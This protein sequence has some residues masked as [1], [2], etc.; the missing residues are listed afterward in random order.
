[1]ANCILIPSLQD[2]LC[3]IS[4]ACCDRPRH[5]LIELHREFKT[6]IIVGRSPDKDGDI[7]SEPSGIPL[8]DL[9]VF[10][11]ADT[12][13][14]PYQRLTINNFSALIK[15]QQ[16]I[17]VPLSNVPFSEHQSVTSASQTSILDVNDDL[18]RELAFYKQSLDAVNEARSLLK[19]EG[20]A[21]TRPSDYYAEMVKTD[22][23][24]GKIKL[25]MIDEA[26]NK[27]AAAEARKQRDLKKFGKQVQ[28]SKL[29]ARDK[30]KRDMLETTKILKRSNFH[31]PARRQSC[32]L[33]NCF[34]N[35][36]IPKLSIHMKRICSMW[37]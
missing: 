16:S 34:Q 37:L 21:L 20:I 17:V 1:M 28:A 10:S 8:S 26:A 11:E 13:I 3:T 12:D 33:S 2:E 30:S 14:I 24:M 35:V 7:G 25:K 22:E 6:G 19:S 32:F 29:Q 23:H 36:V 5:K 27:K 9:E 31:L 18:N 15:A 4:P